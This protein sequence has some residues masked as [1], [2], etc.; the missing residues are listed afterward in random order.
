MKFWLILNQK[1]LRLFKNHCFWF[2]APSA[3]FCYYTK[4]NMHNFVM[5]RK[6]FK[7]YLLACMWFFFL[8][9]GFRK[10]NR[11]SVFTNYRNA[12]TPLALHLNELL[13]CDIRNW[14]KWWQIWSSC[15]VA[16]VMAARL[17]CS[18]DFTPICAF[19]QL[20][21]FILPSLLEWYSIDQVLDCS[22]LCVMWFCDLG[23]C[24]ERD[25]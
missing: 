20:L 1:L 25:T 16:F 9:V 6:F 10:R 15:T 7:I 21:G 22:I 19:P 24:D 13:S 2:C 18:P 5:G 12:S 3:Q 23:V 17:L 11:M 8:N 14:I 4:I